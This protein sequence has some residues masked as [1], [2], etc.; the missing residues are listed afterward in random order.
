MQ[1]WTQF[2]ASPRGIVKVAE[3]AEAQGWDGLSVVDSQ[4]LSGDP[5]VALAM[6]ATATERL[7]LATAV[8]NPVTRLAAAAAT[9]IASVDVVSR[10]RATFGIG[11]GDSALAH[12]GRSP[13]RLAFFDTFLAQLQRYLAGDSVPFADIDIPSTTA[14]PMAELGLADAP[15]KSNIGWLKG[16]RKVPVEVAATGPKVIALAACRADRVMFALGADP[17][18]IAWGI[19][20]AKA[21]RTAAGLDPD[22]VKF[23]AYVNAACHRDVE[24]ARDLAKGGLTTFARFAVMHGK[25]AGPVSPEMAAA[26]ETLRAAYDMNK[27]THGD[28][29]QAQTLT[30]E[31]IDAYAIVGPPEHC[32]ERLKPLAALGLDKVSVS[33]NLHMSKT[34][35]GREAQALM[36][37]EVLPAAQS[38]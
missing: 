35:A 12:L 10:G 20:T 31:F 2:A 11:R 14:P 13:A 37:A 38:L 36:A 28:S 21:A 18:R 15:D 16:R 26:L 17:A 29:A 32:I 23:G 24:I 30:P 7:Q 33:G 1:V 19:E 3:Q 25:I 8:S 22:G 34:E 6:A 5:F 27:H 9:G 4:N